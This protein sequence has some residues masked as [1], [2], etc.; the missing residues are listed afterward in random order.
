M[1]VGSLEVG[2]ACVQETIGQLP[3]SLLKPRWP[4]CPSPKA[5]SSVPLQYFMK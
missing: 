5:S 4:V 3:L 1:E 2:A